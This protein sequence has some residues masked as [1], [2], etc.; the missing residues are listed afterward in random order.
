MKNPF[1]NWA[2]KDYVLW[3][4][5]LFA[6]I[7]CNLLVR[8]IDIL[9][10][11][12]TV[13]GINMLLFAAKGNVLGQIF[14]IVFC[15]M[16]VIISY[17]FKYYGEMITYLCM[18]FPIA[19]ASVITW[20]KNPSKKDAM[21]VKIRHFTVKEGFI[22]CALS[23]LVTIALYFVL[24]AF[25]TPNLIVSTISVFTSFSAAYL[26]MRRISFY[27]LAYAANDVVLIVLWVMA[28]FQ[29]ISYI[30]VAVNFLIFMFNDIYAYWNWHKREKQ[31]EE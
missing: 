3:V 9:T 21:V 30:P 25:N 16:Y 7:V 17:R 28:S 24:R 23:L 29:D 4:V 19:V 13:I 22:V 5:S 15:I 12:A 27:A 18:S 31:Q 14:S 10:L 8:P 26:T 2:K 1:S 11:I 20:L 6:V